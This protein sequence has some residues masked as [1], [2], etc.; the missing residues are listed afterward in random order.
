METILKGKGIG[1]ELLQHLFDEAVKKSK[2]KIY[3]WVLKKN[4]PASRFYERNGFVADGREG[5]VEG[6][7]EQHMCYVREVGAV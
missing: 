6:T 7:T 3:A 1:R 2:K 4:I 5:L